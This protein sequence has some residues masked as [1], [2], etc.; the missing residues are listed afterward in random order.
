MRTARTE[1]IKNHKKGVKQET[2]MISMLL[3][4]VLKTFENNKMETANKKFAFPPLSHLI[5]K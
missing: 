5:S 4:V 2:V 3:Y 1:I